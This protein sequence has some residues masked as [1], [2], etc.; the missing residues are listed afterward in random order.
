MQ[1]LALGG[2]KAYLKISTSR[3]FL[4]VGCL[5]CLYSVMTSWC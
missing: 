5:F 1:Q 4:L 3:G 2:S